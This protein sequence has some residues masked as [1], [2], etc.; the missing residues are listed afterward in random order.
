MRKRG[1]FL[2]IF[3]DFL[4]MAVN[5]LVF[6]GVYFALIPHFMPGEEILRAVYIFL[7]FGVIICSL[8]YRLFDLNR[9]QPR[10]A[11]RGSYIGRLFSANAV[12]FLGSILLAALALDGAGQ[13]FAVILAL[14]AWGFSFIFV[15]LRRTVTLRIVKLS[16]KRAAS[17]V[18]IVGDNAETAAAFIAKASD[19]DGELR[20]VGA[21]GERLGNLPDCRWLGCEEELGEKLDECRPDYAVF[22]TQGYDKRRLTALVNLC[23][24]R[25]VKVYFL[26][27][28]YGFFKSPRQIEYIDTLPLINIHSTPLDILSNAVIKRL[29]DILGAGVLIVLTLPIMA[30]C[31]VGVKLSSPGPVLFK[32]VRVGR[33]GKPFTMLK[34]RSMVEN[35]A[36]DTFWSSGIDDR[37]TRFGNFIRRT[38]IDEL[39]QLFNVLIGDMSLVGPRPE[40]PH[41]VEQFRERIPLYMVKHYVK[42]GV[43]GLAQIRRLR[44]DTS[45]E[46][47]IEADLCY[48]EDWSLWLD[49]KILCITPLRA[50][51]KSEKFIKRS[52]S[53]GK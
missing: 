37:K 20:I 25:C 17:S 35:S 45:V 34:F 38:S 50:I 32:Q 31:A 33:L 52:N 3:E 8:L 10:I 24:D 29:V 23:D 1:R 9:P 28:I 49:I 30:V 13:S 43:T 44:G 18:M 4:D 47:R 41:F 2:K 12:F 48:I 22:A 51:N 36:S 42:P 19:S 15:L 26:P 11:A 27:V 5:G 6:L 16:R 39:P 46:A 14:V 7:F 21:V 40:I 53:G